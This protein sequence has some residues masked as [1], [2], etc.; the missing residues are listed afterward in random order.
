MGIATKLRGAASVQALA[1][2]HEPVATPRAFVT[3]GTVKRRERPKSSQDNPL[4]D[5]APARTGA[6]LHPTHERTP[7]TAEPTVR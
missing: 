6:L 3:Q 4:G 7:D 2:H 5:P 1:G